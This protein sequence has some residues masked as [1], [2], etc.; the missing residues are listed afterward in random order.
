MEK[1]N[2]KVR[3]KQAGEIEFTLPV[4]NE[5]ITENSLKVLFVEKKKLPIVQFLL[6]CNA[7][8]T[9]DPIEKTGLANLTAMMLDEGAGEFD[10]LQLSDEIDMIGSHISI[11]IDE[12]NIF[13]SVQTLK[14]NLEKSFELFSVRTIPMM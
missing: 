5:F 4:I 6:L 1:I 7:G 14:E 13:I 3:P 2:R 11:R 8:S 9:S 12:D 10:S